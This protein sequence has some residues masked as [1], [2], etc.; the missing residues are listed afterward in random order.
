[1][2]AEN[3]EIIVHRA[4]NECAPENS[5]AGVREIRA[6]SEELMI[7]VDICITADDIPVLYHDLSLDRLCGDPR[8][9][10]QTAYRDLPLRKDGERI[11]RLDEMLAEFPEQR[12]L[13]DVRT[14]V[15]EDFLRESNIAAGIHGS[16]LARIVPAVRNLLRPEDADRMRI[17]VGNPQ[18]RNHARRIF[19]EFAIDIPEQYTRTLLTKLPYPPDASNV[20]EDVKRMYV[21]FREIT[22]DLISWAHEAGLKIIANHAPSRRSISASQMMLEQCI[23][24]GM[25]GLT[26]SPIDQIFIATWKKA[27][28]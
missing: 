3:F 22:Q 17:V 6:L 8:L 28:R 26:A 21:R 15:H 7:E 27:I 23:D 5:L 2:S 10:M 9:L 12:F 25:D 13:L 14:H 4:H 16:P 1:M 24:W 18:H 20:G 11:A 19:P